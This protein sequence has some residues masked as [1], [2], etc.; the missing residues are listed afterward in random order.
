MGALREKQKFNLT[1]S[2]AYG[3]QRTVVHIENIFFDFV[4]L[5]ASTSLNVENG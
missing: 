5:S 1:T 4:S 3:K 2:I